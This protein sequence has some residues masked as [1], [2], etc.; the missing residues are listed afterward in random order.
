MKKAVIVIPTYNEAANIEKLIKTIFGVSSNLKD[1]SISCV[2]VDSTS[3]DGTSRLVEKL[4]RAYDELFLLKTGKEGLGKAYV[5][6]FK[7]ALEKFEPDVLF[8]MDA[9]LS[10]DPK[11]ILEFLKQIDRGADFVVGSRYIKGGSIPKDWAFH[12][13]LFSVLG[14]LIIRIGFMKPKITDWTSGYRAIKADIVKDSLSYIEKFSGY[15]FQVALLDFALK[16]NATISQVPIH[17]TDRVHGKSKINSIQ[18]II[19]TLFYVFF[20]SSFI[21]YGLVGLGGATID[22]G[23]SYIIIEIIKISPNRYWLATLISAEFAI[24]FNFTANNFWS[25][26]HKK[27]EHK[28]SVFLK[29]F[30]K[31]NL[32]AAGALAIQA[33]GIQFFTNI[34]GPSYWYIYKILIL[35]LIVIP[36]SYILYNKIIWKSK[37]S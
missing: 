29:S 16:K 4:Q 17:F 12:R 24:A 13:K 15:V 10:H 34:L 33:V 35:A 6:G 8:E 7:Y 30:L 25:F 22:F 11:K 28:S 19:Q 18:F 36:Y 1:W 26:A 37:K 31:F 9:D 2:V 21:K 5:N 3:P 23:I 14:N 20:K 32:I 27:L